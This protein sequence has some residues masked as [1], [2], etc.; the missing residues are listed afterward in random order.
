MVSLIEIENVWFLCD[1]QQIET[2][3]S[4]KFHSKR[5]IVTAVLVARPVMDLLLA[6]L[7][8]LVTA[9]FFQVPSKRVFP[10]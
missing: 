6:D 1:W 8:M 7:V 2:V 9:L 3:L 10:L 4:A 5:R